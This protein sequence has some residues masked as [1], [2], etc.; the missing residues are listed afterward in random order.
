M[1]VEELIKVLEKMP[2]HKIVVLTDPEDL[3][4]SNIGTVI[5]EASTVKISADDNIFDK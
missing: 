2:K 5:E 3:G 1:S 4:W